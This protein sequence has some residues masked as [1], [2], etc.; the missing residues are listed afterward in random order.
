[1]C[2]LCIRVK[3]RLEDACGEIKDLIAD[4]GIEYDRSEEEEQQEQG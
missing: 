4:A 2:V 3:Y 1:M